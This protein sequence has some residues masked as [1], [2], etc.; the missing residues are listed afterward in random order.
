M[1]IRS[2]KQSKEAPN[3]L[4]QFVGYTSKSYR[5]FKDYVAF[6]ED[7]PLW[8]LSYKVFLQLLGFFLML[9]LSPF[10]LIGLTIAIAAVL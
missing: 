8:M 9:L 10:L 1:K 2:S 5:S 7:D 3:T 6:R 4:D